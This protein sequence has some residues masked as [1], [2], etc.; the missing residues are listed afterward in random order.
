MTVSLEVLRQQFEYTH[1]ATE[2]LLEAAALLSEEELRRDFHTSDHSVLG[3][4]VHLFKSNRLWLGRFQGEPRPGSDD[5]NVGDL[6]SLKTEWAG[7]YSRWTEWLA[8]LDEDAPA[9]EVSYHDLRGRPWR[10]PLWQLLLHVVNHDTH[11]RG[12]VSGFI[13]ALGHTPPPLDLVAYYRL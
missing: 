13:R 4:L 12:Q 3:T 7:L 6:A 5:E 11:H 8:S 9:A 2:R 10:Q 1:W